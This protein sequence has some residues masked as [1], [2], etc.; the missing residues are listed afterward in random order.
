MTEDTA[1]R[2]NAAAGS[3]ALGGRADQDLVDLD[4]GRGGQGVEDLAGDVLV[5]EGPLGRLVVEE[6]GVGDARL[7]QGDLDAVVLLHLAELLAQRFADRRR[8]ELGRRVER[9]WE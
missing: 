5:A 1:R 4:V 7:D 6:L 8:R 2:P 9:A 3:A